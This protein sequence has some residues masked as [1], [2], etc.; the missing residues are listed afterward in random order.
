MSVSESAALK[1]DTVVETELSNELGNLRAEN[2]KLKQDLTTEHENYS[3]LLS[4]N[5]RVK[6]DLEQELAEA[7]ADYALLL[8][9][10]T[11]VADNLREDIRQ[12]RSQ[13]EAEQAVRQQVQAELSDLEKRLD[14]AE[15]KPAPEMELSDK[16]GKVAS[17]FKTLLAKDTKLVKDIKQ[18]KDVKLPKD[19]I[20]KI[21]EILGG[22]DG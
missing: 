1:P 9:S 14:A 4:A 2:E 12:L 5:K 13:L 19:T 3:A 8:E 17:F 6:D 7:R 16:A 11:T 15:R 20:S 10:S 21:E 22:G 18:D